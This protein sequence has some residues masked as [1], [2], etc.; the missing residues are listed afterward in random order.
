M[1]T[2][3]NINYLMYNLIYPIYNGIAPVLSH[4]NK[5]VV[6]LCK[7]KEEPKEDFKEEDFISACV[8]GDIE[9]VRKIKEL[10]SVNLNEGLNKAVQAGHS[11][12]VEYLVK[13]GVTNL[14]ENLKTACLNNNFIVAEILVQNGARIVVGLRVAKSINIIKML[15][16]YEQ[17]SEIIS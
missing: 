11:V 8:S 1:T 6:G 10:I 15:R 14:D 4:I 17:N 2:Q 16:R 5:Y 3:R 7:K 13:Q 9:K 12:V